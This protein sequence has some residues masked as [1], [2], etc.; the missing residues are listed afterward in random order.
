MA[1]RTPSWMAGLYGNGGIPEGRAR[2]SCVS[3][4]GGGDVMAV[5]IWFG[6]SSKA[7][8]RRKEA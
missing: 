6:G 1:G 8:R 3:T 5:G 2:G 7:L 4:L